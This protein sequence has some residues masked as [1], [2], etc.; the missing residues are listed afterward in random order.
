MV[1]GF[2][3]PKGPFVTS[4]N[5]SNGVLGPV[6]SVRQRRDDLP[7]G[8]FRFIQISDFESELAIQHQD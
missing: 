1:G 4:V 5:N 3:H 6:E 7:V 8:G 2:L